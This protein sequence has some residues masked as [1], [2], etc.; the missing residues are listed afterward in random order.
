MGVVLRKRKVK[1]GGSKIKQKEE[2]PALSDPGGQRPRE[3]VLRSHSAKAGCQE[4]P[5]RKTPAAA[6]QA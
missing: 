5:R 6:A 2:C 1:V 4:A 3:T